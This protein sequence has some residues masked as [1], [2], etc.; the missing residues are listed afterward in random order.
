MQGADT[1]LHLKK[2]IRNCED[3]TQGPACFQAAGVAQ[4]RDRIENLV[5]KPSRKGMPGQ[6]QLDIEYAYQSPGGLLNNAHSDSIL[7]S[8][9]P[10]SAF[11]SSF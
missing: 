10:R 3:G 5:A 1:N 6:Q 11:L 4:C 2:S 7:P 9:R 8:Q